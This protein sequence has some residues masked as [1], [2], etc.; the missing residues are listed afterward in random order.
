MRYYLY[1]DREAIK[2][3]YGSLE[4]ANFDLETVEYIDEKVCFNR[5]KWAFRS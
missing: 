4:D 5:R 2:N 1:E 3:I